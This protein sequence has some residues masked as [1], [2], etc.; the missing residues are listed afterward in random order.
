MIRKISGHSMVPVL[1][2]N[3]L[4]VGF[5]KFRNLQVN[6]VIIFSHNNREK[7]K[8]I[9]DIRNDELYVLGDLA[10]ESTDS[11]HFGWIPKN[12]VVAKV[13]IPRDV[14]PAEQV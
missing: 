11:R 14:S 2:P 7:I 5:K 1:P 10:E 9:T 8:R 3:T 6:D 12:S 4:I 13:V